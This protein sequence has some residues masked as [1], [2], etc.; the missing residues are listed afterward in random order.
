MDVLHNMHFSCCQ[1]DILNRH[2]NYNQLASKNIK[3][4]IKNICTWNVTFPAHSHL[5][6][7][8]KFSC[9]SRIDYKIYEDLGGGGRPE[10]MGE[11]IE[12]IVG[13]TY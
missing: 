12:E 11:L 2:T 13:E 4:L 9:R 6:L 8:S 5:T 10:E 3:Q 7:W 1:E